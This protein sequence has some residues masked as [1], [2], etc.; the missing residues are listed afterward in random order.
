[1]PLSFGGA[2]RG[3]PSRGYVALSHRD[4]LRERTESGIAP[5]SQRHRPL[6]PELTPLRPNLI[7]HRTQRTDSGPPARVAAPQVG[8]FRTRCICSTLQS[9]VFQSA[10]AYY[11]LEII[12]P[13]DEISQSVEALIMSEL[14]RGRVSP[15]GVGAMVTAARW[16]T[17]QGADSLILGC[18]DMTH[19]A[20]KVREN[21]ELFAADTTI[22]HASAAAQLAW[23]GIREGMPRAG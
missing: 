3:Q 23:S 10:S 14:I 13:P 16:F 18:T 15:R 4:R 7:H 12:V 8:T 6:C 2:R 1:M 20:A 22:I 9:G 11:D 21:T 5:I 17:Q 19:L